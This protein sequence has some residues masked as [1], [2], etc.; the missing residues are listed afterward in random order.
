MFSNATTDRNDR[1]SC[2]KDSNDVIP[3]KI[4]ALARARLWWWWWKV[5]DYKDGKYPFY[6]EVHSPMGNMRLR[7][8]NAEAK[9][10]WI[11]G[12]TKQA[13]VLLLQCTAVQ[14]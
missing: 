6:F 10:M 8:E 4:L 11:S 3:H 2:S 14:F 1:D 7:T 5:C 12:L 9:E 13:Q